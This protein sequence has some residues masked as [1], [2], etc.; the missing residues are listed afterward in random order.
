[1]MVRMVFWLRLQLQ[2]VTQMTRGVLGTLVGVVDRR[3]VGFPVVAAVTLVLPVLALTRLTLAL[4]LPLGL[5]SNPTH[6][7]Q[8]LQLIHC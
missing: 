7:V 3:R 1:L 8:K 6:L 5:R 2:P 4:I